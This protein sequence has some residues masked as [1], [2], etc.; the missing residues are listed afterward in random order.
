MTPTA[1]F[2]FILILIVL[3]IVHEFGHFITAKMTKMRVDEFAFGFPPRIFSKKIGETSY[4][5]NAIPLGGYVSIFGENGS[6]EDKKESGALRH[7]RAFGNR[8]WWAQLLVLVAGVAM[9]MVLAL[10]IFIGLSFGS[11]TVSTDDPEYGS[12]VKVVFLMVQAVSP[13]S[14]AF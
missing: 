2:L 3:V 6:E 9:N 5:F 7:P 13:E 11:V 1:V 4:S 12:R 10:V 8:P 14:P